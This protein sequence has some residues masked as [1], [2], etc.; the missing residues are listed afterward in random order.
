MTL[1]AMGHVILQPLRT[2]FTYA[3]RWITSDII[4]LPTAG[5]NIITPCTMILWHQSLAQ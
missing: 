4:F 2:V 1:A 3:V 5:Q